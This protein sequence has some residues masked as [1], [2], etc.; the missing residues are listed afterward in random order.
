MIMPAPRYLN[1]PASMRIIGGLKEHPPDFSII[2]NVTFR[3][4]YFSRYFNG[5]RGAT[6]YRI[7]RPGGGR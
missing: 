2:L 7:Y 1:V 4:R 5:Y 6:T 3:N